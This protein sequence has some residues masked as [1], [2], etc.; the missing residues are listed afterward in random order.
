MHKSAF[1]AECFLSVTLGYPGVIRIIRFIQFFIVRIIVI[2]IVIIIIVI[3]IIIR[4]V[5]IFFS[6]DDQN[7]YDNQKNQYNHNERTE[8]QPHLAFRTLEQARFSFLGRSFCRCCLFPYGML[9]LVIVHTYKRINFFRIIQI[10]H[11]QSTVLSVFIHQIQK[12]QRCVY[13]VFAHARILI[14]PQS[15]CIFDKAIQNIAI[16]NTVCQIEI[17]FVNRKILLPVCRS[18]CLSFLLCIL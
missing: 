10:Q 4:I 7:H 2:L 3:K 6:F 17:C 16:R 1:F 11:I 12:S 9:I 18:L 8:N 15:H 5:I 14:F 13:S